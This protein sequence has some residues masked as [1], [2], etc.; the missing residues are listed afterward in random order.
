M[1]EFHCLPRNQVLRA[2]PFAGLPC[3]ARRGTFCGEDGEPLPQGLLA[4]QLASVR[5][6]RAVQRLARRGGRALAFQ[7]VD[8]LQ[9]QGSGSILT[10]YMPGKRHL[11][12]RMSGVVGAGGVKAPGYP[13]ELFFIFYNT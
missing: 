13:I 3:K 5:S 9:L 7:A 11:R 1:V 12:S 10:L 8:R 2:D 6:I 4:A